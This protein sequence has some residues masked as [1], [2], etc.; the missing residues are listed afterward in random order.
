MASEN[1][2]LETVKHLVENGANIN[3]KN[4]DRDTP[5][6]CASRN[7]HLEIVI[8]LCENGDDINEKDEYGDNALIC[9]SK[10]CQYQ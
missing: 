6:I 9:F 5:L 4:K 7:G 10:G 3:E 8:Y 1:G 2:H